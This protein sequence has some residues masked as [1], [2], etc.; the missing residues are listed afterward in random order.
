MPD[1]AP[2]YPGRARA[3]HVGRVL[4]GSDQYL[5]RNCAYGGGEGLEQ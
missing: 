2:S 5:P 1:A 4:R 3:L